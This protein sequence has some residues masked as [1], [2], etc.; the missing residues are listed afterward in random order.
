MK[1]TE[2]TLKV[3]KAITTEIGAG[4]VMFPKTREEQAWNNASE[5]ANRI[6]DDYAEGIGLFQMTKDIKKGRK[7]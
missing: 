6:V 2:A 5:R 3:L 1:P 7:P 4:M